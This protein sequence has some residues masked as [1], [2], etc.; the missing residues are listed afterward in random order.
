MI[1]HNIS[2]FSDKISRVISVVSKDLKGARVPD[3]ARK[4][5]MPL[6]SSLRTLN[7]HGKKKQM[8]TER[9]NHLWT[10]N[11]SPAILVSNHI[12]VSWVKSCCASG[13]P[14]WK[15]LYSSVGVHPDP[16]FTFPMC[17]LKKIQKSWASSCNRNTSEGLDRMQSMSCQ[18]E[19]NSDTD[20]TNTTKTCLLSP[21][22]CYFLGISKASS[23]L[24]SNAMNKCYEWIYCRIHFKTVHEGFL[25]ETGKHGASNPELDLFIFFTAISTMYN[26]QQV[27]AASCTRSHIEQISE[28]E[29]DKWTRKC[30]KGEGPATS[31]HS[32]LYPSCPV[33]L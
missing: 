17:Q 22:K 14:R 13:C 5:W 6:R 18:S 24:P 19:N 31:A 11:I 26:M 8:K 25:C 21:Q 12:I 32:F 30:T 29:G 10:A 7:S 23:G 15:H 27:S 1:F 16:S 33:F 2:S 20:T 4:D 3:T 9:W 28:L